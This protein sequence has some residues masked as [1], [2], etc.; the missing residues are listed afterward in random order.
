M[1]GTVLQGTI[2]VGD[3]IEIP[4]LG[5]SKKVKSIQMF[6]KGVDQVTHGDRA[7][8]CVTQFDPSL[9]ERGLIC[10]PGSTPI[11]SAV[12]IDLHGIPYF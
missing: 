10:S 5:V 12:I 9:L 6:R 2:K 11:S 3:T 7:G 1:T 8:V 4:S